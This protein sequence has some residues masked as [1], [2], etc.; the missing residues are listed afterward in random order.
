VRGVRVLHEQ[1]RP[2]VG[3][4]RGERRVERDRVI[5]EAT[6]LEVG[7]DLRLQHR[8]DVGRAR[9]AMARPQLLGDAG[10]A[11]HVAALEHADA[12]AGAREVGGGGQPVVA[13]ADDD[14][15]EPGAG[16]VAVRGHLATSAPRASR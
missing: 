14:R 9:D 8:D 3:G 4:E 11:D 16:A 10:A 15:V 6:Q 12:H 2:A 13:G 5:A 1:D 7:D